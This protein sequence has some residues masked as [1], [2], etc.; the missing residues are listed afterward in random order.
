MYNVDT[1]VQYGCMDT[2]QGMINSV[3]LVRKRTIPTEEP[4]LVGEVR[5]GMI[6]IKRKG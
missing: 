4:P 2:L 1:Q 5:Q 3:A 6:R